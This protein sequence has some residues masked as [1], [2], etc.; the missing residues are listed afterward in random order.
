[1]VGCG[2]WL[3]EWFLC[4]MI[5]KNCEI[6]RDSAKVELNQSCFRRLLCE[7]RELFIQVS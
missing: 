1:M 2:S 6:G 5:F 7:T 3:A 4:R